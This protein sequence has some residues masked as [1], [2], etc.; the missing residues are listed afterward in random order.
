MGDT[1]SNGRRRYPDELVGELE[2]NY[3]EAL[4]RIEDLERKLAALPGEYRGRIMAAKRDL[5]REIA[6]RKRRVHEAK[7]QLVVEHNRDA[8]RIAIKIRDHYEKQLRILRR[9]YGQ[10]LKLTIREYERYQ[11]SG[12]HTLNGL[13]STIRYA[14]AMLVE[15]EPEVAEK[16]LGFHDRAVSNLQ[17]VADVPEIVDLL[18]R[19]VQAAPLADMTEVASLIAQTEEVLD[20]M[21]LRER[22]R[23]PLPPRPKPQGGKFGRF[24]KKD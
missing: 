11:Y 5:R 10:E 8:Q 12:R 19:W 14:A 1:T 3:N 13:L 17:P 4:I 18:R 24:L 20:H 22:E 2:R 16:V 7:H 9:E 15:H 21:P 23:R 6:T